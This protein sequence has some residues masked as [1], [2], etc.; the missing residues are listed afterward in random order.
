[1]MSVRFPLLTVYIAICYFISLESTMEG[2]GILSSRLIPGMLEGM[3]GCG[4][5]SNQTDLMGII[6]LPILPLAFLFSSVT[7][8]YVCS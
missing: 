5:S 4:T 6:K 3:E 7:G 1:M 8:F 2:L